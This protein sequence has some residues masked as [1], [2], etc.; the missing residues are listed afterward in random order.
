MTA[1]LSTE[2]SD[3]FRALNE[4]IRELQGPSLAEYD[5]VCECGDE[6]CTR[7]MRMQPA[8]YEAARSD[9]VQFA[10]VPGHEHRFGKVLRRTERYV[11][12][13]REQ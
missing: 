4:R 3:L 7:V 1:P 2:S 13:R 5:L 10:V 12:V 8:E 9:P 6:D 11:V